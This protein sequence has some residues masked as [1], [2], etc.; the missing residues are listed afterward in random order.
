MLGVTIPDIGVEAPEVLLEDAVL[1]FATPFA[2]PFVAFAT[3]GGFLDH[4]VGADLG[5]CP[6]GVPKAGKASSEVVS[7]VVVRDA[8]G[9]GCSFIGCL[10]AAFAD[11]VGSADGVA[12]WEGSV[13]VG[14]DGTPEGGGC[15]RNSSSTA[16]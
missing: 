8:G 5:A 9:C 14:T 13:L 6:F 10:P 16:S 12:P 7:K 2:T 4:G 15:S 11:I 3:D 1:P